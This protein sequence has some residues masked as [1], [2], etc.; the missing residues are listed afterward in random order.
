MPESTQTKSSAPG[1]DDKAPPEKPYLRRW[2]YM[3]FTLAIVVVLVAAFLIGIFAW[4]SDTEGMSTVAGIVSGW[5]GAA[6]GWFFAKTTG[7]PETQ[8]PPPAK[9]DN[10]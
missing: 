9:A 5:V 1:G 6:L 7:S 8:T 4:R 3:H 2:D 10:G